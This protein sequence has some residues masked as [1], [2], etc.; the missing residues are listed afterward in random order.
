MK[1]LK[2]ANNFLKKYAKLEHGLGVDSGELSYQKAFKAT[3]PC[4]KCDKEAR[5]AITILE[6]FD[7]ESKFITDIHKNDPDGDGFWPHDATAFAIYICP[8]IKCATATTLWNQ[9]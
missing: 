8:D 7:D 3:T 5:L 4:I 6:K 2:L 9:A 1:I